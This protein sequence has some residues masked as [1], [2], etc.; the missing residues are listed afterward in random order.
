MH[1]KYIHGK[2]KYHSLLEKTMKEDRNLKKQIIVAVSVAAGILTALVLTAVLAFETLSRAQKNEAERYLDEVTEQYRN[3]MIKQIEGN[4]Q[5]LEAL[6]T[7]IGNNIMDMDKVMDIL[8]TENYQN[9]FIRMGFVKPDGR[10]DL[11]DMQ[12]VRVEN[13]YL[14][15]EAFI[16]EALAGSSSVSDTLPDNFGE[17]YVNCYAV[18][19]YKN[20]EL[21]GA[22]TAANS[23]ETFAEIINQP[24]FSGNAYLHIIN[25]Q[26]DF[27]IRSAHQILEEGDIRS[28][29]ESAILGISDKEEILPKLQ[30]GAKFF[31]QFTYNKIKYWM[32]F[33]PIGK[34]GWYILCMVPRS[35]LN[36]NFVKMTRMIIC[37]FAVIILLL[38]L[39][40]S[41]I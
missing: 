16:R 31:S 1:N 40:F 10:G 39:L 23:S 7:I 14:G 2:A 8:E 27:I 6:A 18:P 17:G 28:I 19:V 15:E 20:G 12:G 24:I 21:I 33:T 41:Y 5:T 29:F 3:T 26:G 11:V 32:F 34:N 30:E 37:I 13:V 25:E 35:A 4:L 22:L 38:V 36:A 9:D